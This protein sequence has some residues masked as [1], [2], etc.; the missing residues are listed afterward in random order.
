M[1]SSELDEEQELRRLQSIY[2]QLA[3]EQ[4][5]Q[6]DNL[7]TI[8]RR[9]KDLEEEQNALTNRIND[10]TNMIDQVND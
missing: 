8:K 3:K 1:Q 6:E 2:D 4:E 7:E 9:N 10:K 5:E